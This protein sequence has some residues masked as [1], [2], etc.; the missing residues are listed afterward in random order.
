MDERLDRAL[1]SLDGL[2]V[3]DALGQ[4][5]FFREIA[6]DHGRGNPPPGP[7]WWT[8]DTNMALSIVKILHE[9]GHID[10]DALATSFVSAFDVGRQYG[11]AMHGLIPSLAIE[12]WSTASASLFGG[13]GSFGNGGAMRIAPLGAYYADDLAAAVMQ[14]GRASEVTHAHAEASA[15]AIAVAVAAGLAADP[16]QSDA[17]RMLDT[18]IDLTPASEVRDRLGSAQRLGMRAVE[19]VITAEVGNGSRVSAQDTVP[20]AVWCALK[21]LGSYEEA[22]WAAIEA[23]GDIDTNAAIVG[24]IVASRV[25]RGGIPAHWLQEREPLPDWFLASRP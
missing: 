2:S 16:S 19:A 13:L 25:G 6:E 14:A 21:H 7:W 1:V 24:G 3:A 10:Q 17:L 5:F 12:H 18:V 20:F 8:D 11:E 4:R 9:F 15:G 23:G 22:V